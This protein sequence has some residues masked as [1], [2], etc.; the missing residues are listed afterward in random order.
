M[1]LKCTIGKL[2]VGFLQLS[3]ADLYSSFKGFTC[4]SKGAV[5]EN[6]ISKLHFLASFQ[7]NFELLQYYKSKA[8]PQ[9]C[10][11]SV[12]LETVEFNL[13]LQT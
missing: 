4:V 9:F 3:R 8:R 7:M 13:I 6:M 12:P 1:E 2:N 10:F 5:I 11:Y